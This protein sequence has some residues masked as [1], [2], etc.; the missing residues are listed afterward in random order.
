[1]STLLKQTDKR[2]LMALIQMVTQAL[3][4]RLTNFFTA[5]KRA[6]AAF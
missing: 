6:A 4:I 1:M 5:I 3:S 2:S